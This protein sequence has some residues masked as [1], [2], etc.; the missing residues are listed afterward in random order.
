M[1]YQP[2]EMKMVLTRLSDAFKAGKLEV[3]MVRRLH[4]YTVTSGQ[5]K[6]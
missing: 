2:I 5:A 6:K 3:D 4:C 1:K